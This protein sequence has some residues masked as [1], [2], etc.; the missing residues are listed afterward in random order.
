MNIIR[1]WVS[2]YFNNEE[3][4]NTG[5]TGNT[6]NIEYINSKKFES[7]YNN[8]NKRNVDCLFCNKCNKCK[9]CKYSSECNSSNHCISCIQCNKCDD[10]EYCKE[11]KYCNECIYCKYCDKCDKCINCFRCKSCNNSEKCKDCINCSEC[12]SNNRCENCKNTDSSTLCYECKNCDYCILCFYCT[13]LEFKRGYYNNKS[14]FMSYAY[15]M[16]IIGHDQSFNNVSTAIFKI[17]NISGLYNFNKTS[18]YINYTPI[19]TYKEYEKHLYKIKEVILNERNI[20]EIMLNRYIK[21]SN[22]IGLLHLYILFYTELK[23]LYYFS[24]YYVD[25]LI[26][27]I[28]HTDIIINIPEQ[29]EEMI[30]DTLFQFKRLNRF[31]RFIKFV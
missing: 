8:I 21:D 6:R 28:L 22:C 9:N 2:Y 18:Y 14:T 16:F 13:N 1:N 31:I 20:P 12:S 25:N 30:K 23:E 7:L 15:E 19:K 5:N 4:E 10:C 27:K 24:N 17:Y 26:D 3:Y 11:C 29:C